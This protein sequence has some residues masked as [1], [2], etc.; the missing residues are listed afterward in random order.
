[1][2]L[3]TICDPIECD[4]LSCCPDALFGKFE[5]P[6]DY[7]FPAFTYCVGTVNFP[8]LTLLSAVLLFIL[9]VMK[10]ASVHSHW[11]FV[12]VLRVVL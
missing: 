3:A 5:I 11:R 8:P 12:F 1:M 6:F 7:M 10:L 4:G 9:N 2:S